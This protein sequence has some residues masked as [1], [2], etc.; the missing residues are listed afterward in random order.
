MAADGG[1]REPLYRRRPFLAGLLRQ[2]PLLAVLLTVGLGLLVVTV[3]HWRIGIMVMGL[4][5]LGGAALRIFLPL[6]RVG[7]L[8]V[9]TRTIDVALLGGGGLLVVVLAVITPPS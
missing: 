9:R 6:R 7:F 2:L 5:L 8:A 3:G 4:A 1:A